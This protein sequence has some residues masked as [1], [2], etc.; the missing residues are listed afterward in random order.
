MSLHML[1]FP[2]TRQMALSF[3]A[4]VKVN[5]QDTY[6]LKCS[7]LWLFLMR[8]ITKAESIKTDRTPTISVLLTS[9]H[10]VR[11]DTRGQIHLIVPQEILMFNHRLFHRNS[12]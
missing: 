11:G 1:V 4:V 2:V 3:S 5:S 12:Q 9:S 7:L 10:E 8:F 6:K